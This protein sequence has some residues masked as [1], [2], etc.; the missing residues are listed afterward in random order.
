[1]MAR[2]RDNSYD[3]K[4]NS[5]FTVTFKLESRFIIQH[6]LKHPIIS[7]ILFTSYYSQNYSGIIDAC[8]NATVLLLKK[9]TTTKLKNIKTIATWYE[10][11]NA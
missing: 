4:H 3:F 6:Q 10:I 8:L 5:N 11:S 1:M 9:Y 2:E 7:A